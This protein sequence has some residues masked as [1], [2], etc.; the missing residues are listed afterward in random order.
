MH[1][2]STLF[3]CLPMD[4][5]LSRDKYNNTSNSMRNRHIISLLFYVLIQ[6]IVS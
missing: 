1:I 3:R 4:V 2:Y 5:V 6:L